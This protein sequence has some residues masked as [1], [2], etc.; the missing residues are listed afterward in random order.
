MQTQT[1]T[2]SGPQQ[3]SCDHG[4]DYAGFRAGIADSFKAVAPDAPLFTTDAANL[5][6]VFL[7]ALPD[8]SRQ[9]YTCHACRRFV[10]T[11]G[12]L[13]AIDPDGGTVPVM[14]DGKADAFFGPAVA[15]LRSAVRSAKVTGVFLSSDPAWGLPVNV[16]KVAPFQWHH[17]AVTPPRSRLFRGTYTKNASQAMAEKLEEHGM[18]CRSFGDFTPEHAAKALALLTSGTFYRSEKCIG[19]ATWLDGL[20]KARAATK[21]ALHRDNLVWR[22][23]ATAP[24]GFCHVRSGMIGTLLEDIVADLPVADI[25]RK[26]AEKMSPANYQ[27]ATAAPSTGQLAQAEKISAEMK[28]AGSL[29]RRFARLEDVQQ[30]AWRATS[31]KEAAPEVGGV[32]A[33]IKAKDKPVANGSALAIPSNTMTW[34]KFQRTV[35]PTAE[36]IE[37]LIPPSPDRLMAL[38]TAADPGAPPILQWD[39]EDSR[40]AVSWYYASGIDAEIK[41]RVT[42]AGGAHEG[43]DIRASLMWNNRNDLDIHVITPRG[44]E[45]FFGNKRGRCGGSLD[46]DMNVRGETTTPIE[47]IRW[48]RGTAPAGRYTVFVENYSFHE[49]AYDGTPFQVELEVAGEVF[50]FSGETPSRMT[51][52][53]SR[54][55]VAVIDYAPGRHSGVVT[56]GL[57]RA[58]AQ[59]P[60]SWG[61]TPGKW[62]NVTGIVPSPNLWSDTPALHHGRHMFFLLD[63]CKDTAQ[64]IGRGF[65]VETLRSELRPI[66]QTLEAYAASATITGAEESTACGLG[67]TDNAPWGLTLRVHTATTTQTITIDRWE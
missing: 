42:Q 66:R 29:A 24:V 9:H 10:N 67:M 35:L 64:G 33:H 27:R 32:F 36:R 30:F 8:G 50:M 5:F 25:Q 60:T 7:G 12:G 57:R 11:Y 48:M 51:N 44:E 38:V 37:A 31:A 17:M 40:N 59:T 1:T 16:S 19:V 15:A 18:L 21:N 52:H 43:C 14:W 13:V 3:R 23:V 47:N 53:S 28:A 54:V 6:D 58:Q 26:F 45:V 63:G 56:S 39:R 61:V 55:V 49:Y 62:A 41:R 65:F 20:H 4:E 34:E 22:A 2:D 46:V